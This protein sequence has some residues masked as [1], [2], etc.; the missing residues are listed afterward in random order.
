MRRGITVIVI[1][2]IVLLVLSGCTTVRDFYGL[3]LI[4]NWQAKDV[5]SAE[6]MAFLEQDKTNE[7]PIIPYT[8]KSGL[9]TSELY[10]NAEYV[11]IFNEN[12][13][14]ISIETLH[15]YVTSGYMC[16]NFAV[17]LH[18]SAE[19]AK[20]R[21][22]IVENSKIAHAFNAFNTM[23]KGI[24]YVDASS[25]IDS[26]AYWQDGILVVDSK[27]REGIGDSA[28]HFLGDP[29]LFKVEW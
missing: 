12:G 19:K 8:H 5:S 1:V 29:K 13:E 9:P 21:C 18:N 27:I 28:Q 11:G 6:L 26:F 3:K 17:G 16:M 23:D 7:H 25:G 22:A 20:I 4:D 15:E 14:G 24:V 2:F 10:V